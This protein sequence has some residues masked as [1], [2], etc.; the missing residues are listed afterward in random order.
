M[1][2]SQRFILAF[3]LLLLVALGA[4]AQGIG[5]TSSLGG[6]VT[7][8]GKA[9]PGATVTISSP[10][11]QGV[12]TAVT[13]DGGGYNFPSLPPGAYTVVIE[14]EGLQKITQKVTLL[15][16]TPSRA[17]ADLKVS[18]VSEAITVTATSP[19]VLEP[20]AVTRTTCSS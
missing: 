11:L 8:E 2:F 17:D 3:S 16:A 18:K 9:L 6:T 12:R 4:F 13:G 7:S 19:A 14:L 5:T 15:L 1:R 20:T 10:A